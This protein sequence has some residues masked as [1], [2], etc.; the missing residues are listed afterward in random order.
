MM[1]GEERLRQYT[2]QRRKQ[3]AKRTHPSSGSSDG[4]SPLEY[5]GV[6]GSQGRRDLK[7][8][9]GPTQAIPRGDM[10]ISDTERAAQTSSDDDSVDDATFVV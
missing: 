5:T 7:P 10:R 6:G 4:S 9:R 1:A 3:L 8:R 2:R